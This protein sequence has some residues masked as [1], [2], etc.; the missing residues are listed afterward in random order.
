MPLPTTARHTPHDL[1]IRH[2]RP[3]TVGGISQ[4]DDYSRFEITVGPMATECDTS[5]RPRPSDGKTIWAEQ[6]L[7]TPHR[8][9]RRS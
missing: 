5:A 9:L 4:F 6:S 7:P 8:L 1:M 2:M 3:F